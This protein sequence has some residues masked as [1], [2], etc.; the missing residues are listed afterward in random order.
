VQIAINAKARIAFLK[1]QKEEALPPIGEFDLEKRI[2]I[3]K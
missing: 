3:I 2:D 1:R